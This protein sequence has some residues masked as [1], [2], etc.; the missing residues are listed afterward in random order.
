MSVKIIEQDQFKIHSILFF[1][2]QNLK[3]GVY[4]KLSFRLQLSKSLKLL[5]SYYTIKGE[6]V[7]HLKKRDPSV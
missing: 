4:N 3:K 5:E 1:L 7:I 6:F 2:V